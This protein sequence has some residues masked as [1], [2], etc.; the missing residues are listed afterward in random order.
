MA[1]SV[2]YIYVMA[3][4]FFYIYIYIYIYIYKLE[5]RP[6]VPL[7]AIFGFDYGLVIKNH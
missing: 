6:V 5:E 7:K 3:A 2:F 1:T 4:S